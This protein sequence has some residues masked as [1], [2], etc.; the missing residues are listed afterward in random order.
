MWFEQYDGR[1]EAAD[2]ITNMTV[3]HLLFPSRRYSKYDV[4]LHCSRGGA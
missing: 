3:G 1:A 2:L 4:N